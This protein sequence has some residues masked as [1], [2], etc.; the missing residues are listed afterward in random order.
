MLLGIFCVISLLSS[1]ACC[2]AAGGFGTLSWLW[3]LPLSFV[4]TFVAALVLWFAVLVILG[5]AA[6]SELEK[7]E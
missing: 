1:V 7:K 5:A 2:V 3:V 4:G 6:V